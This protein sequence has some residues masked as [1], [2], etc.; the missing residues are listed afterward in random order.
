MVVGC[1][2]CRQ[3]QAYAHPEVM[4]V[5]HGNPAHHMAH[6]DIQP[7]PATGRSHGS[8]NACAAW[9]DGVLDMLICGYCR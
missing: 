4:A 6:A 1:S 7:T 2:G 8:R 5:G 9:E 3:W